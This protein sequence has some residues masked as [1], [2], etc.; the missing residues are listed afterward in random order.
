MWDFPRF[1]LQCETYVILRDILHRKIRLPGV[2]AFRDSY[3]CLN[4]VSN[5]VQEHLGDSSSYW[6]LWLCQRDLE[7]TLPKHRLSLSCRYPVGG[8][9]WKENI[10]LLSIASASFVS[11]NLGSDSSCPTLYTDM[12]PSYFDPLEAPKKRVL[13]WIASYIIMTLWAY[14]CGI[15]LLTDVGEPSPP[16][17]ASFPF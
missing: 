11:L 14:L 15:V 1:F 3:L 16:W 13:N 4:F 6:F 9:E 7:A 5:N 17:V 2:W 10:T 12:S 8:E